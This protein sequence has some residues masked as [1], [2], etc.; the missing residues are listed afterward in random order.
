MISTLKRIQKMYTLMMKKV[1]KCKSSKRLIS[2][3]IIKII[4][5]KSFLVHNY[6][7]LL[8]KNNKKKKIIISFFHQ[9]NKTIKLS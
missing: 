9:L 8:M 6:S 2:N 5:D 1:L 7:L 3:Y 4:L